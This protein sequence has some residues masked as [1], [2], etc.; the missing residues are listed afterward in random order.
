MVFTY[1]LPSELRDAPLS[2]FGCEDNL[3]NGE[4]ES[5]TCIRERPLRQLASFSIQRMITPL[6]RELIKLYNVN[7]DN[8]GTW[9]WGA[10]FRVNDSGFHWLVT[11][12]LTST[13]NHTHYNT[14]VHHI[15]IIMFTAI[16][17]LCLA[18]IGLTGVHGLALDRPGLFSSRSGPELLMRFP[19][20]LEWNRSL[21]RRSPFAYS[22]Y[23]TTSITVPEYN[24]K[25]KRTPTPTNDAPND[26]PTP[27]PTGDPSDLTTVHISDEQDF[28]L[29]LPKTPNGSF[30][31]VHVQI[32]T[33]SSTVYFLQTCRCFL[34][35]SPIYV[36]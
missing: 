18:T 4:F 25:L 28:A 20:A 10:Y 9:S 33:I 13:S 35:F 14:F 5:K 12:C 1:E 8:F 17:S 27:A 3:C 22:F 30:F 29:L 26:T 32:Q 24:S 19:S 2:I 11:L 15:H 6:Y 16:L 21:T 36:S 23:N 7:Q 34:A 31:A